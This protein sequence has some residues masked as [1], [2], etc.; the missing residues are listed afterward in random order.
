MSYGASPK[1]R[2]PTRGWLLLLSPLA[3]AGCA[4]SPPAITAAA[5]F[6]SVAG[7]TPDSL[8]ADG[9][10]HLAASHLGLASEAFQAAL[11]LDGDDV[12][13]HNALAATYD[14]LGRFDLADRHYAKALILS[15]EDPAVLNNWGWSYV[16]RGQPRLARSLIEE[17]KALR[18]EDP[19]IAANL[20]QLDAAD[21]APTDLLEAEDE[22]VVAALEPPR[23][24]VERTSSEVQ[25]LVVDADEETRRAYAEL[26]T[27]PQLV[28]VAGAPSAVIALDTGA[29]APSV[30]AAMIASAQRPPATAVALELSN[31]V[32][33]NG[34]AARLAAHLV[35]QG[36]PRARLTNADRWGYARSA[37]YFRD[38]AREDAESLAA[39]LPARV[40]LEPAPAGQTARVRLLLGYDLVRLD[41]A[42]QQGIPADDAQSPDYL[43]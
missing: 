10:A 41:D 9:K 32:G 25:T 27:P 1:P 39:R 2:R 37:I 43:F 17:A 8:Y 18:P 15:P 23:V 4:A 11:M 42:I 28:H 36:A 30:T 3:L 16:L 40:P 14:K 21:V 34:M 24:W 22:I 38:G 5:P 31:G 13:L 6:E 12:D 7:K 19:V 33:R 29:R 20:A 26:E 35:E